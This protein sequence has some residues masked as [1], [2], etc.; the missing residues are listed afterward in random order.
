MVDP[1]NSS[2]FNFEINVQL[3]GSMTQ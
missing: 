1:H 3:E 2:E